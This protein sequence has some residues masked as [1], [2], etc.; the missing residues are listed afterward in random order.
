MNN[1]DNGEGYAGLRAGSMWE[2]SVLFS[3]FCAKLN[4]D[5]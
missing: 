2:I 1:V 3:Q 5:L 4:I